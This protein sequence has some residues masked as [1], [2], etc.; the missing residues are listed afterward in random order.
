MDAI[1]DGFSG[2]LMRY[3]K[4]YSMDRAVSV[5]LGF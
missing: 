4:L 3:K 2:V 1:V 5:K